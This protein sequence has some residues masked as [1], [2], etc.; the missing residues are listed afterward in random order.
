MVQTEETVE[1]DTE[2]TLEVSIE[3]TRHMVDSFFQ[4]LTPEQ[5]E[6]FRLDKDD[7]ATKVL[8]SE[9]LLDLILLL[10][11]CVL[12][13]L[14][15]TT[16]AVSEEYVLSTLTEHLPQTFSEALNLS[17]ELT[18]G[19]SRS[20]T[21]LI[22]LQVAKSVNS[23]L[24][25]RSASSERSETVIDVKDTCPGS[26]NAMVQHASKMI[27]DSAEKI[28]TE[29]T[30]PPSRRRSSISPMSDRS[31]E[32]RKDASKTPDKSFDME[33]PEPAEDSLLSTTSKAV[34]DVLTKEVSD[35]IE[36]LL[37]DMSDED[38]VQLETGSLLKIKAVAQDIAESIVDD[39]T[40]E[41][42]CASL[43]DKKSTKVKFKKLGN[44]IKNFFTNQ[45]AQTTVFRIMVKVKT[46]FFD[47]SNVQSSQSM[48]EL[49]SS[50]ESVFHPKDTK[51]EDKVYEC[52]WVKE[53]SKGKA[54][55]FM[56]NLT[57][58]LGS[59]TD[60]LKFR[61]EPDKTSPGQAL[62]LV[63]PP[64]ATIAAYIRERVQL[65]VG[66]MKWWQ[67]IQAEALITRVTKLAVE[68]TSAAVSVS[69]QSLS[70]LEKETRAKENV[71]RMYVMVMVQKL[72]T[73]ILKNTKI[74]TTVD[75]DVIANQLF[76]CVWEEIQ[77]DEFELS[78]E[79]LECLDKE[80]L[81]DLSKTWN[82]AWE[83]M[84]GLISRD[85]EIEQNIASLFKHHLI[86]GPKK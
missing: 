69:S 28:Q 59:Y 55:L 49:M 6:F 50:V 70:T 85:P 71:K 14:R 84:V 13:K 66:L 15:S 81:K 53:I 68:D 4:R 60:G 43:K 38:F 48:Q 58:L 61:P 24:S 40:A 75:E 1:V 11:K 63:T 30:S 29:F 77:S 22:S 17:E 21:S 57:G 20:L 31:V 78:E 44:K 62:V 64:R 74:L 72:L 73:R 18:S 79:A 46:K 41:E 42:S 9:F 67:K 45:F 32:D 7:A 27:Q 80:I 5:L 2:E 25:A 39:V 82:S 37:S 54:E 83:I 33:S 51:S 34:E 26:L 35:L 19:S 52:S 12:M 56:D 16:V 65:F 8:L 36:P 10:A 3:E 23:A 47:S 76:D 86:T